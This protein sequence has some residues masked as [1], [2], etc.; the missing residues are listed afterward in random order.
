MTAMA[1]MPVTASRRLCLPAD[2][3][4]AADAGGTLSAV[5]RVLTLV[6]MMGSFGVIGA[7]LLAVESVVMNVLL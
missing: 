7:L 5:G 1:E 6:I 3:G 2:F 4:S